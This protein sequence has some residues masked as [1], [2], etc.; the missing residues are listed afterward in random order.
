MMDDGLL[1]LIV[2]IGAIEKLQF[3]K[4]I[5]LFWK[6]CEVVL[7]SFCEYSSKALANYLGGFI[8]WDKLATIRAICKKRL[9]DFPKKSFC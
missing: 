2:G 5:A 7:D 8:V 6:F 1:G 4:L 3:Q 9:K